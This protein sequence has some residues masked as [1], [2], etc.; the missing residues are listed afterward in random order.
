MAFAVE[1][2]ASSLYP[3]FENPVT[4]WFSI[5]YNVGAEWDGLQPAPSAFVALC[6]GF[7]LTERLGC[8]V[9]SYNNLARW[10]NAYGVDFGFNYMVGERVQLDVAANVDVCWAVSMGVVW[11]INNPKRR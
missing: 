4:D 9:E 1:H 2:V 6:L 5:G 7:S 10:G 8:F 11:Q 3:L